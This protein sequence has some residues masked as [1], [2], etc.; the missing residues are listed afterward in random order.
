MYISQYINTESLCCIPE[1]NTM[2]YINYTSIFQKIYVCVCLCV[3]V[4]IY[5]YVHIHT[6]TQEQR[7][8]TLFTLTPFEGLK[9][10][11]PKG[12]YVG[13]IYLLMFSILKI[14]NNKVFLKKIQVTKTNLRNLFIDGNLYN[15][16]G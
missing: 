13:Y 12:F 7:C 3:C 9:T 4:Y 14:K 15:T 8:S 2:L 5:I 1:P 6:Y 11:D 10:E 16:D